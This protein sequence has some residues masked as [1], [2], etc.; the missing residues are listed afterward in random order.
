MNLVLNS[1]LVQVFGTAIILGVV[2]QVALML[3]SSWQK[4]QFE[5]GQQDL[6]S[7][8]LR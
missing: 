3:V 2:F 4:V 7:E 6:T 5:R 1:T 8:L